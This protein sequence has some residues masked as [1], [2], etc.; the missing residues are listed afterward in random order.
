MKPPLFKKQ[1]PN[2]AADFG[3]NRYMVYDAKQGWYTAQELCKKL[4]GKLV[5]ID[6]PGELQFV[7]GFL[8]KLGYSKDGV[9]LGASNLHPD[10]QW[11]WLDN[12][13]VNAATPI[14]DSETPN[15]YLSINDGSYQASNIGSFYGKPFICEWEGDGR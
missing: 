2:D 6:H 12:T 1:I 8:D 15:R 3:G 5:V 9:W 4:G 14:Q 10:N 7:T 11:R 13:V